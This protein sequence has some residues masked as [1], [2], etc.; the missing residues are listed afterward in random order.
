MLVSQCRLEDKWFRRI[1]KLQSQPAF[2]GTSLQQRRKQVLQ[3]PRPLTQDRTDTLL[4]A[5]LLPFQSALDLP[6]AA[7]QVCRA[8]NVFA[9]SVFCIPRESGNTWYRFLFAMLNPVVLFLLEVQLEASGDLVNSLDLTSIDDS[10]FHN[11]QFL[12]TFKL[13]AF[14]SGEVFAE[15]DVENIGVVMSSVFTAGQTLSS[16]GILQPLSHILEAQVAEQSRET[17]ESKQPVANPTSLVDKVSQKYPWVKSLDAVQAS[18]TKRCHHLMILYWL[19][20]F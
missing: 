13:G 1:E 8:R 2:S 3:C 10:W 14:A 11:P 9:Q 20:F 16:H 12:W 5:S 15:V 17:K 19:L 4:A 18:Q 7:K 6:D